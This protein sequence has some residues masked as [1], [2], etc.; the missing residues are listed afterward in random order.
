M[1]N[2]LLDIDPYAS[3]SI[4]KQS[5]IVP[6]LKELT[7]KHLQ[8]CEQYKNFVSVYFDG[9][10]DRSSLSSLPFLPVNIFKNFELKSILNEDVFKTL[11]SSGTT[12][13]R[14]SKIYLDKYTASLQ[15]RGLAK[16]MQTILGNG[17]R[18]MLVIDS[19]NSVG[20]SSSFSARGAA[21]RGFS[22]FGKDITFALDEDLNL[23][24]DVILSF[25]E[26]NKNTPIF[27]FGFTYL[28]WSKLCLA[29][30]E[31]NLTLDFSDAVMLHGGGWKK[32]VDQAVSRKRMRDGLRDFLGITQAY[33]YYGMV[34]QTGSIYLECD[35]GFLHTNSFNDILIKDPSN[36]RNMQ[37]GEP[38]LIQTF[39][40]FPHS[41]PGHSILTED[42]GILHGEDDCACQKKGKYFTVQGRLQNSEIRGCSDTI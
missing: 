3:T 34:E 1:E 16:L 19:R 5:L 20:G 42:I 11:S 15:Q 26:R 38:G 40:V 27:V 14:T 8:N 37:F 32:L 29:L 2:N 9:T 28:I 22:I 7:S 6:I 24:F 17:R 35:A 30:K 4:E 31:R 13:Q 36:L 23:D 39:S 10:E 18:P 21:I 41:Y 25:M 33:D 12:G